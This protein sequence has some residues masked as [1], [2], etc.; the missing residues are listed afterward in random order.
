MSK[1]FDAYFDAFPE[2]H[3]KIFPHDQKN[4]ALE[5]EKIPLTVTMHY[6]KK[7]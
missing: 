6:R 1:A 5:A 7:H 2:E 4:T 3:D